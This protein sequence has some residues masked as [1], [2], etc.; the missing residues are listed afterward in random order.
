VVGGTA[1]PRIPWLPN[2]VITAHNV[3][4]PGLKVGAMSCIP[5]IVPDIAGVLAKL[6]AKLHA[7]D[8][9]SR[10]QTRNT[11][12]DYGSWPFVAIIIAAATVT[13]VGRMPPP[14]VRVV[15]LISSSPGT[16]EPV[17]VESAIAQTRLPRAAPG[18]PP[19]NR[20]WTTVN[21]RPGPWSRGAEGERMRDYAVTGV[22][23]VT[24]PGTASA[25]SVAVSRYVWGSTPTS[26]ADSHS[27]WKSA[28]TCVPR[29]DFEP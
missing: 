17:V 27:V 13:A 14:P 7:V 12:G 8:P 15:G 5:H 16:F 2:L 10:Q 29:S 26:V 20:R 3:A 24:V 4:H 22:G 18:A 11:L 25:A 19:E 1:T 23:S 21:P 9:K 28:A 6:V